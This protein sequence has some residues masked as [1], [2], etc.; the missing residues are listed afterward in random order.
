MKTFSVSIRRLTRA[1]AEGHIEA[2]TEEEAVAKVKQLLMTPGYDPYFML[3]EEKDDIIVSE[4]PA[5]VDID[6]ATTFKSEE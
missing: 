2:E 4:R 5:R 1:S 3:D 6:L